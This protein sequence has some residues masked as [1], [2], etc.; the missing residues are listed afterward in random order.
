[1]QCCVAIRKGKHK[2]PTADIVLTDCLDDGT[3]VSDAM[4]AD[5]AEVCA[6]LDVSQPCGY[7]FVCNNLTFSICMEK[8]LFASPGNKS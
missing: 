2:I 5:S 8:S 7:M 4:L 3:P 6:K 1:M